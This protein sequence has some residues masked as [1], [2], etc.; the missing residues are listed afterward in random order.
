MT[1]QPRNKPDYF[2]F[3]GGE[4]FEWVAEAPSEDLVEAITAYLVAMEYNIKLFDKNA[5][6]TDPEYLDEF[7]EIA[8]NFYD[9]GPWIMEVHNQLCRRHDAMGYVGGNI[10]LVTEGG[11]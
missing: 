10:S 2:A 5:D 1:D 9:V 7:S 8:W 4:F 6:F 11:G 3:S